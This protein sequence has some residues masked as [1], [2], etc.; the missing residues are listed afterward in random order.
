ML[1]IFNAKIQHMSNEQ[2]VRLKAHTLFIERM[3]Y[4]PVSHSYEYRK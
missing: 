1:V 2:G 4:F 3:L